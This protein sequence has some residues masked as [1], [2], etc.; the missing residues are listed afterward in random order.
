M[1]MVSEQHRILQVADGKASGNL[2]LGK[3]L[4]IFLKRYTHL[5]I[6]SQEM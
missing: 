3:F 4:Y 6:F 1:C 2:G 5:L